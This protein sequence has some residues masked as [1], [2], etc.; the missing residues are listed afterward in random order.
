MKIIIPLAGSR[1][2]DFLDKFNTIK[3]LTKV[4]DQTMLEKF[5]RNFDLKY[6][7]IFICNFKDLIETN[8]LNLINSF[9]IKKQI[10]SVK[11]K[12]SNIIET[13]HYAK[14][15]I[16]NNEKITVAHP[17][18]INFFFSIKKVK[19]KFDNPQCDGLLF[20]LNEQ[21]QS[22]N[23]E[24]HTGRLIFEN[25]KV[26]KIIEK[27]MKTEN[28]KKLAGI[29]F[30]KKWSEFIHYS[31]LTFENQEPVNGRYFVSQVYNEYLRDNKKIEMFPVKDNVSFGL[32]P[33][34]EE[35][36]FWYDYFKKNYNKKLTKKFSFINLIPSCGDG[37]RFIEKKKDFFKPLIKV[38][39]KNMIKKT[40]DSLPIAK[41][42]VVIIRKDHDEKYNFSEKI[43]RENK[44]IEVM[45]LN[46]KTSGMASTCYEYVKKINKKTPLLISSCDYAVIFN[47]K[48]FSNIIKTLNPDVI[49]WT[50]KNYPDA[51]LAPYAYAYLEVSNGLVKKISE[52]KPISDQPHL[53]HIA[54]GIFYFKSA[55]IFLKATKEMFKKKRTINN[56][57]YV[58]NSI[59]E[60]IKK[61]YNV[62][63]FQVEQYICL[64]T[65]RDLN[66]YKYWFKI[67][68]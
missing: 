23:S 47:E 2:G 10:I 62:L 38:D 57:Y 6:E 21:T 37:M 41:K 53:D 45:K 33:Y 15:H 30:F 68:K 22:N 42:N 55:E 3:P 66:V 58:G 61:N 17:D 60:L 50:F 46:K 13:I 25:N 36:N 31:N 24:T 5:V 14:D 51:R 27:S 7:F 12:T 4:G 52:K 34:V 65:P 1:D 63:P 32:V 18:G 28:S 49:I 20:A 16:K 67:F 43:K 56:E 11:N 64:G 8:L 40:I 19:L 54:Q 59:N 39:N 44:N 35:Y 26:V 29:Y 48:K 9:K